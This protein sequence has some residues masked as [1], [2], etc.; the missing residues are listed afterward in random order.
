VS[1]PHGH[2]Y[3]RH[4]AEPECQAKAR[5]RIDQK[6][7]VD[8]E[9]VST[10]LPA[11]LAAEAAET[12]RLIRDLLS[13]RD[14]TIVR[15][16]ERLTE[17]ANAWLEARA[18]GRRSLAETAVDTYRQAWESA[19]EREQRVR[20]ALEIP[21][22]EATDEPAFRLATRLAQPQASE[23]RP[24]SLQAALEAG[25]PP[26]RMYATMHHW[27]RCVSSADA[28]VVGDM[29][30]EARER[31]R[32]DVRREV[33]EKLASVVATLDEARKRVAEGGSG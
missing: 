11:L 21:R 32:D 15:G 14:P 23:E 2:E 20:V 22:E 27:T 5:P 25:F 1:C 6:P 19:L 18:R 12:A 33:R 16:I 13:E 30:E 24:A 7:A 10:D 28:S 8:R 17:D 3:Y 4:C 9:H 31:G 26:E 29:I